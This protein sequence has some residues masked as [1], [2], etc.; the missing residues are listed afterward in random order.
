MPH[1]V[2][3]TPYKLTG[4]RRNLA[5]A[6]IAWLAIMALLTPWRGVFYNQDF[7]SRKAWYHGGTFDLQV[8]I[9]PIFLPPRPHSAAIDAVVRWP[10]QAPYH[11]EMVE[12]NGIGIVAEAWLGSILIGLIFGH[13][14]AIAARR[15]PDLFLQSARAIAYTQIVAAPVGS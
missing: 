6:I 2:V 14:I 8:P 12:L 7:T 15:N 13:P 11:H 3:E 9:S 1:A 5:W 4:P 10:W